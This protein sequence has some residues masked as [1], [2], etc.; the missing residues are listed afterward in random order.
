[1]AKA[2]AKRKAAPGECTPAQWLDKIGYWG[3]RCYLCGTGLTPKTLHMEHRKPL[4]RGGSHWP[5][6]LAPACASCNL[7]KN[8]MTE[9]EFRVTEKL[10]RQPMGIYQSG[11]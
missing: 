5:A 2:T 4:A 1:M 11:T 9:A 7:R 8:A 6:N 10:P 3:W